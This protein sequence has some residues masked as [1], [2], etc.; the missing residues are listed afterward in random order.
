MK[1]KY[2]IGEHLDV[3]I[4]KIVPQGHG[5]AFA[6]DL[7]VFV[8]LAAVGDKV[9][10]RIEQIKG[11]IAFAEIE[12]VLAASPERIEPPCPYFGACGGCNMQ[13]MNYAEQIRAK[14]DIVNDSLRRI[15]KIVPEVP[16]DII[17]SPEPFGYR[18]RAMWHVDTRGGRV[19]Y[20]RR[21]T[22]DLVDIEQ[23][24]VLA[25]ELNE[26]LKELREGLAPERFFAERVSIEAAVGSDGS[27]SVF[28]PELPEPT[29]DI[30]V[31]AGGETFFYSARNFFQGNRYLVDKMIEL[32]V[33]GT[34]GR[35]ALDLYCGVGLFTLPLARR[36]EHVI[37][38][39]G[40]ERAIEYAERNRESARLD[41][42][43]LYAE[44]VADYL[45]S[46]EIEEAGRPSLILLD[47]PRAGTEKAVI[48]GIIELSPTE[49]SYVS[50]EPAGLARDLR[51]LI[52]AGYSIVSITA[53]DL[54]PQTHHVETIVRLVRTEN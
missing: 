47:P 35:L 46:G 6:E 32:A 52:D 40:S 1:F 18:S 20:Y 41:N 44:T 45:A 10:V 5:L 42:V 13:Q 22:R 29:N 48:A 54:F 43:D 28:S 14:A 50:C 2:Q 11:K 53:L 7:T 37:G 27:V 9:R 34:K 51:K 25:P 26:T 23:C 36:F 24:L 39:E 4:K 12:A 49:I 19:G 30:S 38:V 17:E 31:S 3:E 16:I 33:G 15:G 8:P 21:N